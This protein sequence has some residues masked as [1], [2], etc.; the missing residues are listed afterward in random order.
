MRKSF[1]SY[2]G[3]VVCKGRPDLATDCTLVFGTFMN[4]EICSNM[5][6]DK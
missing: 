3:Q 4:K 1:G 6:I 2:T 5:F